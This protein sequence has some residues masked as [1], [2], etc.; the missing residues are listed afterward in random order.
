[1]KSLRDLIAED[2]TG[3]RQFM[4]SDEQKE[5]NKAFRTVMLG[6]RLTEEE[7]ALFDDIDN[8]MLDLMEQNAKCED[9]KHYDGVCGITK[10]A[11]RGT[12]ICAAFED[13][14]VEK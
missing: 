4:Q 3:Y 1:M 9:C 13:K 5:L 10:Q 14:W 8:H 2:P 11:V 6:R 12:T 7:E